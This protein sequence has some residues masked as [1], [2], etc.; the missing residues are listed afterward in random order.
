MMCQIKLAVTVIND[1][2]FDLFKI[3]EIRTTKMDP[4]IK[5]Y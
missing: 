3:S 5:E 1:E 4:L 2:V